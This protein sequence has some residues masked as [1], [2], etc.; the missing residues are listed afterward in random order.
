MADLSTTYLGLQL[1]NPL[2]VSAS[3]LSASI[4][5]IKKMEEA[6]AAAVI[7]PSLFEEQIELK[8][9][10]VD[11]KN[12]PKPD[13]LPIELQHIPNMKEYN[14]GASGYLAHV[15]QA[16]RAVNIP[17]IGSLNGFYG[18]GWVKYARL[19]EAA[20]ADAI[21]LNI[22]YLAGKPQVTG[23]EV[24]KMYLDL[25]RDVK[26][27][28]NVPVAVKVSPY[29]SAL[30]N[31]A[32]EFDKLKVDGLIFFNRFYQPDFD[33]EQKTIVPSLDLSS[34]AELRLRLRWVAM[35]YNRVKADF[36]V[37]GGV[38]SGEDLL[39]SVM[40][41]AKIAM[42]ASVLFT[43]SIDVISEILSDA[44]KW[45]DDHNH[46]TIA[47]LLGVMSQSALA[48]SAALERANYMN[49]LSSL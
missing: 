18:G 3:T 32:M 36:G 11:P 12:P 30:G 37:T 1:K 14:W 4:E 40:A 27:S 28:V 20:G 10:G 45:L 21:E 7:L 26:A 24:E 33:I 9:L 35:L 43:K 6:G 22:Y 13:T 38:H 46:D 17:V 16:K 48:D 2:V 42:I 25:V 47:E 34:P 41:G 29:F 39:K 49:V 5:N 19:I 15:Y 23:D 8:N 31:M 44:N